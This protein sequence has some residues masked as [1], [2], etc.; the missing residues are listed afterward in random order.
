MECKEK[1][2]ELIELF[3]DLIFVYAVSNLTLMVEEPE[4]GVVTWEMF[5]AY[6]IFSMVIIQSWMM[7]TMYVNRCCAWKWYEYVLVVLNMSAIVLLTQTINA[8]PET[9]SSALFASLSMAVGCIIAL[10]LI[11][12]HKS[13]THRAFARHNLIVLTAIEL[14]YAVA[15]SLRFTGFEEIGRYIISANLLVGIVVPLLINDEDESRCIYFP[16]LVERLNLFTIIMFGEAIIS[17]TGFFNLAAPEPLGIMNFLVIIMMFGCYVC[18][19]YFTCEHRKIV[20][21]K[22]MVWCHYPIYVAINLM[23]VAFVYMDEGEVDPLITASL[24]A[25]SMTVFNLSLHATSRYNREIFR[26][27]PKD[28]AAVILFT[29]IGA[30]VMMAF[31]DERYALSIGALLGF[32]MSFAYSWINYHSGM[33]P[34]EAV[35]GKRRSRP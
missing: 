1:R 25:L 32:G 15:L 26:R 19:V 30:A 13:E 16:H 23:T 35:S 6:I 2:V 11:L 31:P 5:G 14:I 33:I 22:W 29:A 3:Y 9:T 27:R 18:Q 7:M 12:Y 20:S 21:H 8:D 28:T 24:M 10:Y 17:V 4:G 34:A